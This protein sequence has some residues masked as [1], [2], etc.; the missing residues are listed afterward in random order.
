MVAF[1]GPFNPDMVVSITFPLVRKG[2]TQSNSGHGPDEVRP[3]PG[4]NAIRLLTGT[5]TLISEGG[6]DTIGDSQGF[7]SL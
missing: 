4:A 2:M 7:R 1:P 5:D 3:G 6:N